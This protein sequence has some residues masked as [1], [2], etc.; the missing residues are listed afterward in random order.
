MKGQLFSPKITQQVNSTNEL[1]ALLQFDARK[2]VPRRRKRAVSVSDRVREQALAL[3][4]SLRLRV[5]EFLAQLWKIASPI[6]YWFLIGLIMV[7]RLC[8]EVIL[9]VFEFRI[10]SHWYSLNDCVTSA[11]QISQRLQQC[12]YWPLQQITLLRRRQDWASITVNHPDYIRFY[13]S[14]WLVLNDMIMGA[15]FGSYLIENNELVASVIAYAAEEYSINGLHRLII[16]LKGWPAGLKLNSEL[17]DFMGDIFIWL[18]VNFWSFCISVFKPH[19][20]LAVLV[21]GYA[22]LAGGSLSIFTSL[23]SSL[24][25]HIPDY[26]FSYCVC[27]YI[28]L[29]A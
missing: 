26:M 7:L 13:N 11:Q 25:S 24:S 2:I 4:N 15:A 5:L 6:L 12:C 21:I 8:A 9:T 18:L 23:R 14:L 27:S 20:P 29:A 22:G 1:A 28:Q 3:Q 17:A 10:F 19:L 16:W